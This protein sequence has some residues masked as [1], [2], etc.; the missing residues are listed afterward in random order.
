MT[1]GTE[2]K[3][4]PG[5]P[6]GPVEAE[7]VP[8]ELLSHHAGEFVMTC[9]D[10][11]TVLSV[12]KGCAGVVGGDADRLF[13]QSLEKLAHPDEIAEVRESLI[14]A[15]SSG[16]PSE[17]TWRCRKADRSFCWLRTRAIARREEGGERAVYLLHRDISEE[18]RLQRELAKAERKLREL[19][20]IDPLTGLYN[21]RKLNER[22]TQL[23][24]EA[25]RGREFVCALLDLDDFES[26]CERF[27]QAAGDRVLM[28]LGKTLVASCRATDFASRYSAD[29][30]VVLFV[31]VDVKTA[32]KL[33]ERQKKT[34]Q[35][36]DTEFGRLT[37]SVG[38]A[39][40]IP[41]IRSTLEMLK[42]LDQALFEARAKGPGS[43]AVFSL[44]E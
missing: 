3:T 13:G 20:T 35:Q 6:G 30:F 41:E 7:A 42:C 44:E 33:V 11:G 19:N 21:R 22:F 43:I 39:E 12:G 18:V 34:I 36:T 17:L 16:A 27:G 10:D 15:P 4:D 37:V 24:K 28:T 2:Q 40:G 23:V 31:D 5:V 9:A 1:D 8:S 26:H 32:R 14:G 38:L 29:Q 25:R